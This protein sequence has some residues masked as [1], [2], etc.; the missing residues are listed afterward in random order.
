M[1]ILSPAAS[2]RFVDIHRGNICDE[3]TPP[4]NQRITVELKLGG[5][6][7][8][9]LAHS[10]VATVETTGMDSNG[11]IRARLTTALESGVGVYRRLFM[12]D[13]AHQ[14]VS[15]SYQSREEATHHFKTFEDRFVKEV[16]SRDNPAFTAK[17]RHQKVIP[18]SLKNHIAEAKDNESANY[19][20]L[21]FLYKQATCESL[22]KL[23]ASM[24]EAEGYPVMNNL[25]RDIKA[26][27]GL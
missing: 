8:N 25:G 21:S 3:Q 19:L 16:Q 15:E 20:L 1:K 5:D 14:S 9:Q 23:L 4:L 18:E 27:L 7:R 11:D 2:V 22:S 17:L 12:D 10:I 24:I 13:Q 6:A 26:A